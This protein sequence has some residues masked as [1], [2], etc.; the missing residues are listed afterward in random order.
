[1]RND[2]YYDPSN[3]PNI[4]E[5]IV[6][7]VPDTAAEI[8]ALK[9]GDAD[10][11]GT[12]SFSQ[13]EDVAA[14]EGIEVAVFPTTTFWYYLYNLDPAKT[15]LFQDKRVRQALFYAVDR[16]AIADN[17]TFGYAEVAQGTQPKLSIAYA[18]DRIERKYTFD[19]ET[20]KQ[21]LAEAGWQDADGDGVL[22][23]D[24]QKLEVEWLSIAGIS[25][26]EQMLAAIQQWWADIGVAMTPTFIDFPT[27]LDRMDA[28]DFQIMNLA[29]SW[30][31]LG[32]QG[33]MFRTDAYDGG[34]NRMKYSNPEFDR[35]D[36]LQK[37]ELDPEARLEL[38][39]Q[40]ANIINEELPVGILIFRDNRVG[41]NERVRNFFP[42]GLFSGGEVWSLPWVWIQE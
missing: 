33:A 1:V 18:P 30:T 3:L 10:I 20:A 21:L 2:D 11:I 23:K 13:V 8:Q 41:Y 34:F 39:I 37:R 5:F 15:P 17:I 4:D 35:L 22:E 14:T 19:P 6:R 38:L 7:V 40:M 9:T 27:L 36:D 25:E 24:G 31:V 32:D 42:V 28:Y 29:F 16:Q 26:Y 12:I